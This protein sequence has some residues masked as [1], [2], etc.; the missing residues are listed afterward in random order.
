[1]VYHLS[2]VD[3]EDSSDGTAICVLH[4]ACELITLNDGFGLGELSEEGLESVFKFVRKYLVSNSRKTSEIEQLTDVMNILIERSN[5]WLN[6]CLDELKPQSFCVRC[7][8]NRHTTKNHGKNLSDF[9]K[10]VN[11]LFF[12][13]LTR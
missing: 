2:P 12:L 11:E 9:D 7:G 4:H 5:P 6:F 3:M 10:K 8:S 13:N 1:M